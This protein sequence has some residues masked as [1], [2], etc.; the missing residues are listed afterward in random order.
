M[1]YE[2]IH[3]S[4]N[5]IK[6]LIKYKKIT[7]YEYANNLSEEEINEINNYVSNSVPK[8]LSDYCNI[9]IN[10]KTVGC[11]L[12]TNIEDGK[13]LDEI[14]IEEKFRNHGIG[15]D[16]IK[17]IIKENDIVYLWVYKEN[18][19]AISLYKRLGFKVIDETDSRYY[20]KYNK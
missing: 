14:Y 3:S 17:N 1:N 19:Q 16:I 9:V 2:L 11:V 18:V 20:M 15:T 5:D 12:I 6:R 8:L 10:N 13:L 7:I 4:N